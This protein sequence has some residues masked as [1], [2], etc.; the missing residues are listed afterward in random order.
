MFRVQPDR[1]E[2]ERRGQELSAGL[3]PRV[4]SGGVRLRLPVRRRR[5]CRSVL[6]KAA[7]TAFLHSNVVK[8]EELY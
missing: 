1:G 4:P 7:L 2:P 3:Q 8:I 5:H 6:S